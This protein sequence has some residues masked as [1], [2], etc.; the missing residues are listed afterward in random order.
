MVSCWNLEQKAQISWYQNI[1]WTIPFKP[2]KY[3]HMLYFL[4][5]HH[6]WICSL[7]NFNSCKSKR[8]PQPFLKSTI[9]NPAESSDTRYFPA[10]PNRSLPTSSETSWVCLRRLIWLICY[11]WTLV[12]LTCQKGM[13]KSCFRT[14]C[15]TLFFC[16]KDSPLNSK[17]FEFNWCLR[18]GS[19]CSSFLKR[20]LQLMTSWLQWKLSVMRACITLT[21]TKLNSVKLKVKRAISKDCSSN[22]MHRYCIYMY[23]YYISSLY[24]HILY[25]HVTTKSKYA[26]FLGTTIFQPKILSIFRFLFF[27]MFSKATLLQWS[28]LETR[29]S[30]GRSRKFKEPPIRSIPRDD[31][32]PGVKCSSFSKVFTGWGN[33][34]GNY[35]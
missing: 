34:L 31:T 30:T 3:T 18:C 11:F 33:P 17:K 24:T 15:H 5:L 16:W 23:T 27:S 14:K 32:W 9:Q 8:I 29:H 7:V 1:P 10:S 4:T 25:T 13:G 2:H 26:G 6:P 19:E 28:T 35:C 21:C 12:A 22:T 20:I